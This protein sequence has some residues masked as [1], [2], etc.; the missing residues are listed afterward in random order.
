MRVADADA[1]GRAVRVRADDRE[2]AAEVH[3]AVARAA[4]AADLG[5]AVGRVLLHVAA[6]VELHARARQHD[7][8]R[9]PAHLL[10]AD[11]R[12]ECVDR[13]LC[14]QRAR[15]EA[16]GPAQD[17]GADVEEPA[18]LQPAGVRIVEQ[19]SGLLV[20]LDAVRVTRT[21][22]DARREAVVSVARE[23]RL[24]PQ[25]LGAR[26]PRDLLRLG[27]VFEAHLAGAAHRAE[28][29]AVHQNRADRLNISTLNETR[30]GFSTSTSR[31]ARSPLLS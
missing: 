7:A 25:H 30:P 2:V 10:P 24:E 18:A 6:E 3:Q 5:G 22:V 27:A 23:L 1:P 28:R 4:R 14:R 9:A 29:Q 8:R 13:R 19:A 21:A 17:A 26:S 31:M 16:P 11:E 15:L 20:H 12:K